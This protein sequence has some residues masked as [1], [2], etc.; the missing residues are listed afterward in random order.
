MG[1]RLCSAWRS[2]GV[3][4]CHCWTAE[5]TAP[6]LPP[7]SEYES[8]NCPKRSNLAGRYITKKYR[9]YIKNILFRHHIHLSIFGRIEKKVSMASKVLKKCTRCKIGG[10]FWRSTSLWAHIHSPHMNGAILRSTGNG[11][12]VFQNYHIGQG[13]AMLGVSQSTPTQT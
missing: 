12:R 2:R 7:D 10:S 5:H 1:A 8:T 3:K 4:R 13:T 11:V 9:Q 6:T